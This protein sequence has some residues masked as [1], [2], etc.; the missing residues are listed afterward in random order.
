MPLLLWRS[1]HSANLGQSLP[2]QEL[3]ILSALPLGL[4][5]PLDLPRHLATRQCLVTDQK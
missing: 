5:E 3:G 4:K 2:P 1:G